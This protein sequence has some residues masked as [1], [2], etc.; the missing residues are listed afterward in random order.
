MKG[1]GVVP[2][3]G[4][5]EDVELGDSGLEHGTVEAGEAWDNMDG[6]ETTETEG[7]PTPS[8]SSAGGEATDGKK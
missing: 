3:D 5:D 7:R 6:E 1:Y 8:S 4:Q 2:Q